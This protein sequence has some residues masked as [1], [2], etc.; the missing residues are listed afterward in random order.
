[1]ESLRDVWY[2]MQE[3]MTLPPLQEE[4]FVNQPQ[5]SNDD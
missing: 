2:M 1:M 5:E 3:A 4:D